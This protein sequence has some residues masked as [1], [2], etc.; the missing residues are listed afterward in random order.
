MERIVGHLVQHQIPFSEKR[1]KAPFHLSGCVVMFLGSP[2]GQ[3]Q[4][5]AADILFVPSK[6]FRHSGG[7]FSCKFAQFA[8][9]QRDRS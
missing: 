6:L 3:S 9:A 1:A 5:A 4:G 7:A 2:V 8:F